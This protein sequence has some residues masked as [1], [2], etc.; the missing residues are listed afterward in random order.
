MTEGRGEFKRMLVGLPHSPADYAAV[1]MTANLADLLGLRLIAT[2]VQDTT[3]ADLASLPCVREWRPLGGGWGPIE[4]PQ[5]D[6]EFERAVA[7][8]RHCLREAV[9][10]ARAEA[11]FQVARGSAADL[12]GSAANVDDIIV[13]IEPGNPAE[14]VTQQFTRL[15]TAAF[16][17]AA[18]VMM[19]PSRVARTAGP[20]AA[21][22]LDRDDP[23]IRSALAIA[24]AVKERLVVLG[25]APAEVTPLVAQLADAA[26]IRIEVAPAVREPFDAASL[27]ASLAPLD[28][29]MVV[30]RREAAIQMGAPA[31]A[32][33]RRVP[34]LLTEAERRS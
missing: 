33:Q 13:V 28:E 21:V 3:L 34:I 17:A 23:S 25:P 30:M 19:V 16:E 27:R 12:I 10:A 31:V 9:G 18:A 24:A 29:R 11:S 2:F 26:G 1:G 20:I 14:R 4:A 15:V 8:A 22:V 7:A 6:R 32:S 5:L